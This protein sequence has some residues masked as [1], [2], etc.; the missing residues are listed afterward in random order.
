MHSVYIAEICLSAADCDSMVFVH[1]CLHRDLWKSDIRQTARYSRSSNVIEIG[2]NR[3]PVCDFLL[4]ANS[5]Q[6]VP[7][8]VSEILWNKCRN[9]PIYRSS[10]ETI[11][12]KCLV[13]EKIVFFLHFGDRQTNKQ[14]D[15]SDALSRSCYRERWLNNKIR[16]SSIERYRSNA[17]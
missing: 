4:V 7:L 3:K 2:T 13:F 5:K 12:L 15:S 16:Y 8:I 17:C 1:A 11:A 14:M 9:V 6:V 10:I